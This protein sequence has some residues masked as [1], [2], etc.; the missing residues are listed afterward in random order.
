MQNLIQKEYLKA[1]EG[2]ENYDKIKIAVDA[3]DFVRG[4]IKEV[5]TLKQSDL[6]R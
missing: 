6:E 4:K 1:F 2:Y 5:Q 3:N